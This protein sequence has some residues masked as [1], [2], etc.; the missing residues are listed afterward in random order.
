MEEVPDAEDAVGLVVRAAGAGGG[1]K[2]KVPVPVITAA[3]T[4]AATAIATTTTTATAT[5][6]AATAA[7]ASA[8]PNPAAAR[9]AA[10]AC[11]SGSTVGASVAAAEPN[12]KTASET[13]TET[14]EVAVAAAAG[15]DSA[16]SASPPCPTS[17]PT[18]TDSSTR[19]ARLLARAPRLGFSVDLVT[20]GRGPGPASGP[21]P[22]DCETS[23]VWR[24]AAEVDA[25]PAES[26]DLR[27]T[28]FSGEFERVEHRCGAR[29]PSGRQCPRADRVRCPLHG[30]IVPRDEHGEP[31]NRELR[32]REREQRAR[33]DDWQVRDGD[34]VH[35][36]MQI[37]GS[38]GETRVNY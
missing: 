13:A 18:T 3:T 6:T 37:T 4:A 17:N 36:A 33:G 15:G 35:G 22:H 29:L 12:T 30:P 2:G 27:V 23:R 25:P 8:E 28:E 24:S 21:A 32:E 20:W 7:S 1:L 11:D 34:S 31:L 38:G 14:A 9:D 5:A 16:T 10:R 26:A 19:R